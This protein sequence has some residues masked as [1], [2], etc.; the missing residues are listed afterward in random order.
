[1]RSFRATAAAIAVIAGLGSA[2]PVLA[3]GIPVI[4]AANVTQSVISA[5]EDV[6]QTLKQI[7]QY[8]TQL[9]QYATQL[10]QLQN[11]A[12]NT[13]ALT[14]VNQIW[15][16][17]NS[18]MQR[19]NSLSNTLT[20][21]KSE[22]GNLDA[23]LSKFKDQSDYST[24]CLGTGCTKAQAD[25]L[26]ESQRF[27]STAQKRANEALLRGTD[28]QA[29]TLAADASR[30]EDL[31]NAVRTAQG[32]V[33]AIQANGQIGAA[34]T[35]EIMKLRALMMS[36]ANAQAL[37]DMAESNK[38]AMEAQGDAAFLGGRFV[39]GPSMSWGPGSF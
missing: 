30:L 37:K 28:E 32:Q 33:A 3:Q 20:I 12:L 38:K 29:N 23:L 21:Q 31:Q 17:A 9:Q 24:S 1:M 8:T 10:E 39:K 18:T 13:E 15:T 34:Q 2:G 6:A 16:A 25:Q 22:L 5:V 35:Q 19:L 14:S 27:A 7:E 26:L 4:D 11:M 36:Q